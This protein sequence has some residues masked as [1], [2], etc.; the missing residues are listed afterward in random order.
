[1]SELP[2]VPTTARTPEEL[3]LLAE[4]ALKAAEKTLM[5]ISVASSADGIL[6][7]TVGQLFARAEA[8]KRTAKKLRELR[9]AIAR[10]R[11][12]LFGPTSG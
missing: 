11:E 9:E 6:A 4:S 2:P 7:P 8:A 12:Q 5:R 10:G 3:L 1:M